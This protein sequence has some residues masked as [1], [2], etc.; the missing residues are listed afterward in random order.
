MQHPKTLPA[1]KRQARRICSIVVLSA[2]LLTLGVLTCCRSATRNP[3]TPA[4]PTVR[5]MTYNVNWGFPRPDLAARAI[6]ESDADIVCLQETTAAWEQH[7]RA[8]LAKHYQFMT[9]KNTGRGA[10]GM[11]FLS[12]LPGEQLALIPSP[13]GWFDGYAMT[14]PTPFGR[15]QVLNVHLRPSVNDQGRVTISSYL[16]TGAIRRREIECFAKGLKPDL[17][18]LIVGDF[19]EDDGGKAIRWLRDKGMTDALREFDTSTDTWRW[20][21]SIITLRKR[22]DHIMYSEDLHCYDAKVIKAGAS[23]HLPVVGVFGRKEED[24]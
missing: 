8:S 2:A 20:Q 18:A 23:D 1:H 22:L 3:E 19:N 5:V 13:I 21:T 12:K 16:T 6:A 10:G 11:A 9:F 17:P 4:V 14:F 24:R 15:I 7:L